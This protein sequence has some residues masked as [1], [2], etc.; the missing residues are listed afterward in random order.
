MRRWSL[1]GSCRD[2]LNPS[3]ARVFEVSLPFLMISVLSTVPVAI[4]ATPPSGRI[5]APCRLI[6]EMLLLY[7]NCLLDIRDPA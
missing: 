7:V 4:K 3:V 1:S 2:Q 6:K 5:H